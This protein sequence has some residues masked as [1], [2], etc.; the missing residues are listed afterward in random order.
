[1]RTK[2]AD[3]KNYPDLHLSLKAIYNFRAGGDY[4]IETVKQC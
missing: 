1:M 3:Y 4:E 2:P